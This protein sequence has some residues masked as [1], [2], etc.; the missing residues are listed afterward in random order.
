M[1]YKEN[2]LLAKNFQLPN[3]KRLKLA[4]QVYRM[5]F[6]PENLM[7][8]HLFQLPSF[9]IQFERKRYQGFPK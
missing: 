6:L 8:S 9:H 1:R 4:T 3:I 7:H 2:K 5:D